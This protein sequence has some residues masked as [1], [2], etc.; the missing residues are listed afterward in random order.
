MQIDAY[1][2]LIDRNGT[3]YLSAGKESFDYFQWRDFN[4][5]L[6]GY[7]TKY[8][9]SSDLGSTWIAGDSVYSDSGP[10]IPLAIEPNGQLLYNPKGYT[11][12]IGLQDTSISTNVQSVCF[13]ISQDIGKYYQFDGT[14]HGLFSYQPQK[15]QWRYNGFVDTKIVGLA[16]TTNNTLYGATSDAGILRSTDN[17][18]TWNYCNGGLGSLYANAITTGPNNEVYVY[19]KY[20]GIYRLSNSERNA[21]AV[22]HQEIRERPMKIYPNPA[23]SS[24]HIVCPLA[25]NEYPKLLEVYDILGNVCLTQQLKSNQ[26]QHT[27]YSLNTQSLKAGIYLVRLITSMGGYTSSMIVKR[28]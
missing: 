4:H 27:G 7:V 17:G 28:P 1:K 11:R 24:V 19:L 15:A 26:E 20:S 22:H 8:F 6:P 21:V 25:G 16:A 2:V 14:D 13:T 18:T 3:L 5:T 10:T 23:T 12:Y 9:K